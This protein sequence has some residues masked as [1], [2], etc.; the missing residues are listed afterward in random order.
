MRDLL[1]RDAREDDVEALARLMTEL[2]YP[3]SPES[4]R[5]RFAR[6]SAHPSYSTLVAERGGEVVGV[7]GLATGHYYEWDE[8]YVR[9]S[10]FVVDSGHRRRGVGQTLIEAAESRARSLGARTVFLNS[11]SHRSGAHRFYEDSGY[12]ATGYRFF[13]RLQG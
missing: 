11:G 7:A 3:S 8:S 10:A 1:I 12:E 6:I 13:K 4:M 5:G 2:G 9:I